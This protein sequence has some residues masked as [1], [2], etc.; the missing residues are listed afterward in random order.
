MMIC[1]GNAFGKQFSTAT[2]NLATEC[3]ALGLPGKSDRLVAGHRSWV[4]S[5]GVW[6]KHLGD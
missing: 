3:I 5:R 4:F 2:L 6:A 1:R